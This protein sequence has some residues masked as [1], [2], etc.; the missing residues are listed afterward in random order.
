MLNAKL[1]DLALQAGFIGEGFLNTVIGTSQEHALKNFAE[2][3]IEECGQYL[4]R[5]EFIGRSDLDWQMV[6]NE[7]F[8]VE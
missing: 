3:I 6:L 4:M 8:E 7:H 1:Q 2:L 5:N